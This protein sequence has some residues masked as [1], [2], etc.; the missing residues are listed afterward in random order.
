MNKYSMFDNNCS[1]F[2]YNVLIKSG[3]FNK[4]DCYLTPTSFENGLN[5][6]LDGSNKML[7]EKEVS[8]M[9]LLTNKK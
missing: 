2:V 8:I 3:I 4:I 7:N 5:Y 6:A 1:K 9:D